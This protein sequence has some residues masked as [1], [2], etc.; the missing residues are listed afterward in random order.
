MLRRSRG[1]RWEVAGQFGAFAV[2]AMVS[3]EGFSKERT[4]ELKG[5]EWELV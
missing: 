3:R 2:V 5:C 1:E 4:F